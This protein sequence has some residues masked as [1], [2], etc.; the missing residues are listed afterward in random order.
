MAV[1]KKICWD[2]YTQFG[3]L[4]GDEVMRV[5]QLEIDFWGCICE[6]DVICCP[7]VNQTF[8]LAHRD[9]TVWKFLITIIVTKIIT[10]ISIITVLLKCAGDVQKVPRHKS[11]HQVL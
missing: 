9:V 2:G 7:T 6:V 4:S 10:V 3:V 11:L 5:V 8:I 1:I